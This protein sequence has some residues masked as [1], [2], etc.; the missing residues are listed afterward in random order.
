MICLQPAITLLFCASTFP[1]RIFVD[2]EDV[3]HVVNRMTEHLLAVATHAT[4]I[5]RQCAERLLGR[6]PGL[7]DALLMP[8]V[9]EGCLKH[10]TRVEVSWQ[11]GRGARWL[12][13]A[14]L[15]VHDDGTYAIVVKAF[16]AFSDVSWP[17]KAASL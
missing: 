12:E 11:M 5:W 10:G 1:N 17:S 2:S 9:P 15:A 4:K 8:Q 3:T 6:R 16:L 14:V 7:L 13:A